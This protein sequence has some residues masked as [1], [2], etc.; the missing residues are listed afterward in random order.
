MRRELFDP[1]VSQALLYAC[2]G[3]LSMVAPE[4]NCVPFVLFFICF[5]C[6]GIRR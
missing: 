1:Q 2:L 5:P 6:V 3:T 4:E